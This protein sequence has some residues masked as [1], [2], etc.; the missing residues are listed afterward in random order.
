[1]QGDDLT[2]KLLIMNSLNDY[3]IKVLRKTWGQH[4]DDQR[5][6]VA[7]ITELQTI[8]D[9]NIRLTASVLRNIQKK[10]PS[11]APGTTKRY[12]PNILKHAWRS[13]RGKGSHITLNKLNNTYNWCNYHKKWV[14]HTNEECTGQNNTSHR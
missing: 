11:D 8:K 3:N 10:T 1:M 9:S 4:S 12:N 2:S 7:L 14:A 13:V 6:I 5:C